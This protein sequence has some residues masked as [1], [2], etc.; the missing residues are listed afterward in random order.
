MH[1]EER[2]TEIQQIGKRHA[3]YELEAKIMP[4]RFL[5]QDLINC[6]HDSIVAI[7]EADFEE[8]K[9]R[10]LKDQKF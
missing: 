4:E 1:S 6:A 5:I 2:M 8:I 7:E 3:V 9:L 10:I